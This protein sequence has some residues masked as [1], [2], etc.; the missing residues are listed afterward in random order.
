MITLYRFDPIDLEIEK[1]DFA[2][3]SPTFAVR[4]DN[5]RVHLKCD[6]HEWFETFEEAREDGRRRLIVKVEACEVERVRALNRL[7]RFCVKHPNSRHRKPEPSTS[8][9]SALQCESGSPDQLRAGEP[10]GAMT[11]P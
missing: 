9:S 3:K 11:R 10:E 7:E 8:L 1:Q 6:S 2:R 4:P 5:T